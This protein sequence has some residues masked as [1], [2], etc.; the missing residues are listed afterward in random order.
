MEKL[1][2]KKKKCSFVMLSAGR[3][4]NKI[5]IERNKREMK[6]HEQKED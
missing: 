5:N 2:K 6:V 1:L 4:S 3:I